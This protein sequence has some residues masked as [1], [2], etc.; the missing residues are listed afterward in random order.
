[1]FVFFSTRH[2]FLVCSWA[3]SD[4]NPW[5]G[6]EIAPKIYWQKVSNICRK[7]TG[8]DISATISCRGIT[9]DAGCPDGGLWELKNRGIWTYLPL[10]C[11]KWRRLWHYN[12][13]KLC[14]TF[15]CSLIH[16]HYT[17]DKHCT[18]RWWSRVEVSKC[19]QLNYIAHW[20]RVTDSIFACAKK[21]R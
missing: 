2:A 10:S 21:E 20:G 11:G 12:K 16:N 17:G 7:L 18:S 3:F 19:I 9:L 13:I 8:L 6:G 1:M 15:L 14:V 5:E 4:L